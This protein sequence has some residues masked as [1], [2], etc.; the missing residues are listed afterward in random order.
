M[1]K[2]VPQMMKAIST[3]NAQPDKLS[4]K[5][6]QIILMD[7]AGWTGNR[8]CAELGMSASR[9]SIIRTSPL[10]VEARDKK[11]SELSAQ[12]MEKRSD[13]LVAGDPVNELIKR[14]CLS[15]VQKKIHLMDNAESEY[16]QNTAASDLLDR[17]GYKAHT[18]KTRVTVE[19]TEKMA[20]RFEKVLGLGDNNANGTDAGNERHSTIRIEKEVS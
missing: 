16:V 18:E 11:S 1:P 6:D 19:V 12:F 8:I 13:K 2:V 4:P 20:T 15:A 17:G 5:M 14:T 9:I 10:F 7:I 3:I